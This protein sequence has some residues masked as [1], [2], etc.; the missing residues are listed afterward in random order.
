MKTYSNLP[1]KDTTVVYE[2]G[3]QGVQLHAPG[4]PLLKVGGGGGG[5]PTLGHDCTLN[6]NDQE[7]IYSCSMS[8]TVAT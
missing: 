7:K 8:A 6:F 2:K 4:P 3:R 5:G 1:I